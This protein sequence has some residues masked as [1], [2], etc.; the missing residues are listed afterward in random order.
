MKTYH[1][2]WEMDIE[3]DSPRLAAARARE[4]QLDQTSI[5]TVFDVIERDGEDIQRI[6]LLDD[7]QIFCDDCKNIVEEI[8]RTRKDGVQQCFECYQG[9]EGPQE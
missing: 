3:A 2:M 5:A 8:Y 6:D 7:E 9:E 4:V 1:I